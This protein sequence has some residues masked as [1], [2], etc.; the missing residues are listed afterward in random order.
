VRSGRARRI[1]VEI[2]PA[3]SD[4]DRSRDREIQP[5]KSR[6]SQGN[7]DAPQRNSKTNRL[8]QDKS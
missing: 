7:P 2:P 1:D 6:E 3:V 5:G 4:N 8:E